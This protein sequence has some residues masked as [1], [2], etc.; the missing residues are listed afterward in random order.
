M[1]SMDGQ[2][3]GV[4]GLNIHQV[5][6]YIIYDVLSEMESKHKNLNFLNHLFAIKN[7][8]GNSDEKLNS[9]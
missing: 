8:Q 6:A 4:D 2:D 7:L 9:G 1:V 5:S 3:N